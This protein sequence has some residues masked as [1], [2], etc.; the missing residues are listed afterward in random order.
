MGARRRDVLVPLERNPLELYLLALCVLSG[1]AGLAGF[2]ARTPSQLPP[3]A[4]AGW[5]LLLVVGGGLGVVGICWRDAVEGL[6]V[7]R[8]A[9]WPVAA[10]AGMYAAAIAATG[11]WLSAVALAGFGAA[12]TARAW[13]ITRMLRARSRQ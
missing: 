13:A 12:A 3:W 1:V 11:Q 5:Y 2:G 9:M 7:E 4:D 10:G 8:A 6:L